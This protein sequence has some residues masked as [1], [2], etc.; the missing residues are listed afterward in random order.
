MVQFLKMNIIRK[1]HIFPIKG[2]SY[3]S[4]EAISLEKGEVINGDREY[5]FAKDSIQFD[6]DNP[7]YFSKRNFLAL[8]KDEKLAELNTS[9]DQQSCQ[10]TIKIKN[11]IIAKWILDNEERH[12]AES[13]LKNFLSLPN[14]Q[15]ITLV[16]ANGGT[17][18]HSFSDVPDKAISLINIQS[19]KDLE[20]KINKDIDPCRFRSNIYF[21]SDRP[22]IEFDWLGQELHIGSAIL[23]V[24][25][26]TK[27]CAATMVNPKNA[28]RDINIPKDLKRYYNHIDMGIY[29]KVIQ[30]GDIQVDDLMKIK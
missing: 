10:W 13:Y 15:K 7:K 11:K 21:E 29:A 6:P 9:F 22:W 4:H 3:Q 23:K 14:D 27:R 16:R 20:S 2:F 17:K 30:G 5:A 1:I 28:T 26:R 24:F 25:K 8:V 12:A 18:K 19:I